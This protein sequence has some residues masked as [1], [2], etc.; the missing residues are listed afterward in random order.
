M[1]LNQQ[2]IAEF[3]PCTPSAPQLRDLSIQTTHPCETRALSMSDLAI[4]R[5]LRMT[6]LSELIPKQRVHNS[7]SREGPPKPKP[8]TPKY[9]YHLVLKDAAKHIPP[10]PLV[11]HF[12]LHDRIIEDV[13]GPSNSWL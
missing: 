3:S 8:P 5:S 10:A 12:P 1:S 11:I 6:S 2:V 9:F 13:A 4:I 7:M